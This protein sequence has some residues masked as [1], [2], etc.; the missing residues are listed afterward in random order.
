MLASRPFHADMIVEG[1][2]LPGATVFQSH[3]MNHQLKPRK[4]A[5]QITTKRLAAPALVGSS[6]RSCVAAA[7]TAWQRTQRELLHRDLQLS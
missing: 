2:M 7:L 3:L 4:S 6:R 5:S 1:R